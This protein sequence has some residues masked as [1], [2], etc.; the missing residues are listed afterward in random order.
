MEVARAIKERRGAPYLILVSNGALMNVD[1]YEALRAA[2]VNQFSI[3]LDFPDE[4]HDDFRSVPGLFHRLERLVPQLTAR[5]HGDVVLNCAV[6]RLNAGDLTRLCETARAWGSSI[7]FSAYSALRT[8]NT[9]YLV[10]SPEDLRRLRAQLDAVLDIKRRGGPVRNPAPDLDGIY[11]FFAE[12]G[13]PGCRAG[14]RFLLVT[15]EGYFRPC[16]HKPVKARSQRELIQRFA[17]T[18][19]CGGCYVAI[20]SYCDKAYLPL[21]REQVLTRLGRVRERRPAD[22]V[23]PRAPA[24]ATAQPTSTVPALPGLEHRAGEVALAELAD[25]DDRLRARVEHRE[26]LL[27][28]RDHPARDRAVRH[29]PLELGVRDP[30]DA[31]RTDRSRR[32]ARPGSR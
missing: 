32:A 23:G 25:D 21:L 1:K 9:D 12:G 10:S 11:R 3:S 13:I 30:R 2:G 16:A 17:R 29:H 18:N 27:E 4:R 8:G 31:A 20:R 6:S 14:Y 5:G 24:R 7:S 22:A 15:P 19:D 26:R 28:L